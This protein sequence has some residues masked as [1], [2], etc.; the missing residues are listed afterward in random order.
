[1]STGVTAADGTKLRREMTATR[2]AEPP[3]VIMQAQCRLLSLPPELR[4]HI[5][6][7]ILIAPNKRI[8]ANSWTRIG[9]SMAIQPPMTRVSRKVRDEAL[10]IF[11]GQHI[12]R[13]DLCGNYHEISTS[14]FKLWMAGIGEKARLLRSVELGMCVMLEIR[15][16]ITTQPGIAAQCELRE[17]EGR[18]GTLAEDPSVCFVVRHMRS[19]GG[20]RVQRLLRGAGLRG[21]G[22]QDYIDVVEAFLPL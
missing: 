5:Y 4:N 17:A 9:R 2:K 7:L 8:E 20:N 1:M 22:P 3:N 13:I 12:F 21:L 15:L 18:E 11:Y 14:I 16:S 10:K 19:N 6:E